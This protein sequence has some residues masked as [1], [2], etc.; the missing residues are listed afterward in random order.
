MVQGC[1]LPSPGGGRSLGGQGAWNVDLGSSRAKP[2]PQAFENEGSV[3]LLF[4]GWFELGG[5]AGNCSGPEETKG[6]ELTPGPLSIFL[7]K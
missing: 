5:G 7:M 1:L 2:G 6:Q 4:G 3:N